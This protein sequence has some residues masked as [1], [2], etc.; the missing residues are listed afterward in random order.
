MMRADPLSAIR[1]ARD[2]ARTAIRVLRPISVGGGVRTSAS[3]ATSPDCYV[4]DVDTS[5][6]ELLARWRAGDRAAGHALFERHFQ[7]LYRFFHTKC[8]GEVD[9][10][11]QG[12][13]LACLNARD[14]FRGE[15]SF[16]TYLFSIAR[17]KLYRLLRDRRRDPNLDVSI[18]SVAEIVTTPRTVIA[19]D[20][21]HRA[22]LDAL[23][24]LPA[25]Q[26]TLLELYYWEE[27]DTR[28]L[29]KIFD[30]RVGTIQTWLFRARG[31][32]RDLLRASAPD[33]LDEL[34]RLARKGAPG[35]LPAAG[36]SGAAI[37]D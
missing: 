14:Q 32:L 7:S 35:D 22:L 18:T 6:E 19:R 36:S 12:T 29:A 23:R 4:P 1:D 10:L 5:D 16:R 8:D 31:K 17:H 37:D 2:M 9:E 11:V 28:A 20:Q 21:A 33:T 15:A 3:T 30:V 34:D 26:Q 27:L 13:M 25:E 24:Q